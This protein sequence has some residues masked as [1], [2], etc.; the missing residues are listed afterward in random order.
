VKRDLIV[1]GCFALY[2]IAVYELLAEYLGV[3]EAKADEIFQL[4]KKLHEDTV[5][6]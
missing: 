1:I 6:E 5:E 3:M 2:L 4:E